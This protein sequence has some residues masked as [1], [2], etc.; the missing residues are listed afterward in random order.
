MSCNIANLINE[1]QCMGDS[2]D[3]INDNFTSINTFSCETS[4]KFLIVNNSINNLN[5]YV[6]PITGYD[7]STNTLS[8]PG[9]IGIGGNTGPKWYSGNGSPEGS[10][11]AARGSLYSD[12]NGSAGNVLYVKETALGTSTGWSAK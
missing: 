10:L 1:D 2:L 7:Y 9:A 4:S 8:L 12:V 6:R 11:D 3:V 5:T